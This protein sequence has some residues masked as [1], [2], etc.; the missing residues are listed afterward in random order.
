MNRLT[1][2]QTFLTQFLRNHETTGSLIPSGRALGNALCRHVGQG[3][4][5][6]EDSRSRTRARAR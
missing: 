3:R 2:Y 6:A 4:G 5:A 1:D